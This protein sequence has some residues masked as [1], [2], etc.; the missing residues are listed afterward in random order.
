MLRLARPVPRG[1]CLATA[2]VVARGWGWLGGVLA[3]RWDRWVAR[4]L[5][6]ARRL[7]VARWGSFVSTRVATRWIFMLA[8]TRR[9]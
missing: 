8:T 3:T 7:G 9:L 4:G 6:V 2:A 5:G 1:H